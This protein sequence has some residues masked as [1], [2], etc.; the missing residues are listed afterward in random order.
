MSLRTTFARPIALALGVAAAA[1]CERDPLPA[2]P[3]A[4]IDVDTDLPVPAVL[5]RLQVDVFDETGRW[6]QARRFALTRKDD[7]PTSF[8]VAV[9]DGDRETTVL[10]RLRGYVNGAEQDYRGERSFERKPY[11]P[12][13][14]PKSIDQL[15]AEAPS[16]KPNDV[17]V[18]NAGPKP[19]FPTTCQSLDNLNGSVAARISVPTRDRYTLMALFAVSTAYEA[20]FAAVPTLHVVKGCSAPSIFAPCS[21]DFDAPKQ[22]A[23][24]DVDLDPGEYTLVTGAPI[25]DDVGL[26]ALAWGRA[27][28]WV[29]PPIPP[30]A[31]APVEDAP[32]L[33]LVQNGVDVTPTVEPA[34]D[35]TVDRLVRLALRPGDPFHV[36]VVLRGACAGTPSKLVVRGTNVAAEESTTCIDDPAS[37]VPAPFDE[38]TP[39]AAPRAT[40]EVGTFA[41]D[42]CGEADSDDERV[43]VPGGAFVLG[44]G[45]AP[46]SGFVS[47]SPRR[48]V[49][50]RSFLVDRREYTVGRYRAAVAAGLALP[51]QLRPFA[52]EGPIGVGDDPQLGATYSERPRGREDFPLV[53]M[54]WEAA[55]RAC[56]RD[57]GDLPTEAQWERAASYGADVKHAY[58]WGDDDP[59]CDRLVAGRYGTPR[60]CFKQGIVAVTSPDMAGDTSV[61]GIE[62]LGGN[63]AELVLGSGRRYDD[64]CFRGTSVIDPVCLEPSEPARVT[65]GGSWRF[66]LALGRVT[67]RRVV[68]VTASR[69]DVGFRCAYPRSR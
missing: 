26:V 16:L 12:I 24:I 10:V 36:R 39:R 57:G 56:A 6:I 30:P 3:S 20:R 49:A 1:G 62:G 68:P 4:V 41:D 9:P 8:G 66:A 58:P 23:R 48:I 21:A 33:T 19:L 34:P 25:M 35:A 15:C 13:P 52:N 54:R 18:Q 51:K 50:V 27:A 65:R 5:S 61:L 40:S 38:G 11:V 2:R 37:L 45:I 44:G 46:L 43:C 42:P 55:R 29:T 59:T 67:P 31:I 53:P 14:Y 64:P 28:D 69:V 47:E 32:R 63:A 17:L 22:A 7:W 60:E